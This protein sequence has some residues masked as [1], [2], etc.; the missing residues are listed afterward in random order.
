MLPKD[1]TRTKV[2]ICCWLRQSSSTFFIPRGSHLPPFFFFFILRFFSTKK[3]LPW[4]IYKSVEY[5]NHHPVCNRCSEAYE[6]LPERRGA[7]GHDWS[8]SVNLNVY[9]RRYV[10]RG[11]AER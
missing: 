1:V 9:L 8:A 5:M 6:R 4:K 2:Q 10:G 3:I 11:K 7:E